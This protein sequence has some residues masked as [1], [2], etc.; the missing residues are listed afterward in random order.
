MRRKEI[1]RSTYMFESCKDALSAAGFDENVFPVFQED[2]TLTTSI[3]YSLASESRLNAIDG[4][5][6]YSIYQVDI[7]ATEYEHINIIDAH[8]Q[9][10]LQTRSA[11][12]LRTITTGSDFVEDTTAREQTY[13][14]RRSFVID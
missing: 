9:D 13:R 11:G 7:R 8:L 2:A 3:V 12:R 14:R 5:A 4:F 6:H 1:D 10:Q